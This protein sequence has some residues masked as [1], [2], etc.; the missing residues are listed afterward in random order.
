MNTKV[1]KQIVSK[2]SELN[3]AS[4]VGIKGYESSTSGEIAN[5]VVNANF[6]YENA[7]NKD[8]KS[9]KNISDDDIQVVMDK[10]FSRELIMTAVNK[11][12]TSFENNQNSETRSNQSI[13]QEEAYL[14]ITNG[15][16]LHLESGKLHIYAMAVSKKVL[17][18]G[19]HKKVNS[20]EL[21]LCQNAIKKQLDFSTTKYRTF[22]IDDTML[23]SVKMSG[24][25]FVLSE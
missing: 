15:I 11:L 20:R 2:F 22:I 1:I 19:E 21:T 12:T 24:E 14:H 23:S 9:L 10:G 7:V 17:V 8:I 18:E 13:A 25:E 6:S 4:F 5:H 16:K 3:G